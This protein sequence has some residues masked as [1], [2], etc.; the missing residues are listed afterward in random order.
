MWWT[1]LA[2]RS[3][4]LVADASWYELLG[5]LR[6]SRDLRGQDRK[7]A[8][9]VLMVGCY[10]AGARV[11]F[12]TVVTWHLE[13]EGVT[14]LSKVV[15]EFQNRRSAPS[16]WQI[17]VGDQLMINPNSEIFLFCATW[18]LLIMLDTGFTMAQPLCASWQHLVKIFLSGTYPWLSTWAL[19][20][21]GVVRLMKG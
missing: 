1:P 17:W 6:I 13:M 18:R 4:P 20:K 11:C 10:N 21:H 9:Q 19:K 15:W 5:P 14:T 16:N 12:L 8:R 7:V 2:N 3:S